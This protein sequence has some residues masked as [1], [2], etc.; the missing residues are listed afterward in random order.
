MTS[1]RILS[2]VVEA[3]ATARDVPRKRGFTSIFRASYS[4]FSRSSDD[5]LVD[6]PEVLNSRE[7]LSS[8]GSLPGQLPSPLCHH[9]WREGRC[10]SRGVP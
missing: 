1:D 8:A 3:G 7:T 10:F 5:E 2:L 4:S 9:V 6:I